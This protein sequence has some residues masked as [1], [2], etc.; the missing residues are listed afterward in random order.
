FKEAPKLL[1]SIFT[2]ITNLSKSAGSNKA[3]YEAKIKEIVTKFQDAGITKE[4]ILASAAKAATNKGYGIAGTT[5]G[6]V[7]GYVPIPEV[8][9]YDVGSALNVLY[10]GSD[11]TVGMGARGD[12]WRNEMEDGGD[13]FDNN[14]DPDPD[15]LV[16]NDPDA[17][18]KWANKWREIRGLDTDVDGNPL[19]IGTKHYRAAQQAMNNL[20]RQPNA[21]EVQNWL[22]ANYPEAYK[23]TLK[24]QG[25]DTTNYVYTPWDATTNPMPTQTQTETGED[26]VA[27]NNTTN[28]EGNSIVPDNKS[29]Q[30]AEDIIAGTAQGPQIPEPTKVEVGKDAT[31]MQMGEIDPITGQQ[32][33]APTLDP[34]VQAATTQAQQPDSIAASTIEAA[35]VAPQEKI[36]GAVGDIGDESIAKAAKVER[37]API[38]A[39]TVEIP[40]GALTQRVVGTLSPN[41]TAIAAQASGTTLSKVTRAK[42]QLR[43][44]GM[45]EEAITALGNDP[46]ELEDRLMDLTEAERG[47]IG[48]LPEEALVS[49]QI[50]SLLKGMESGEI[51]TWASP[52]VAAVEQMLAQRGLSASTVGRDN[53]FNAI[54]QSAVP[55]AQ[56]NAQAIQQSVAQT[57]DIESREELANVQMRQQTALQ[58]A[59]N[60]FQ[61]DM[62]QFS[63]DQQTALSNSKFLQTVSLTEASNRQQAIIQDA[64]ITSQMNLTDADFYQKTQIQ[65]SQAFLQMDLTNLN[66]KQ[67]ANILTAQLKQQNMLSN[68]AATNASRQ[69]NASSENQTQQFMAGLA[70]EVEKFNVQQNNSMSQFNAQSENANN[71]L[72]Y[73][74]EADVNKSNAAMANE[75]NKFNTQLAFNRE[76]WNKQNAQAVE[77]SNVA[78]RRQANT[79]NTAAANQ[80]SMQN[81]M[82]A[83]NLNGQA[84]SFL[85]QELRDQASF[86]FQKYE[87]SENRKAELYAQAIANEAQSAGDWE[88]NINSVGALI[89]SMFG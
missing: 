65:N 42:K 89:K 23:A 51:P 18:R 40:E 57:R 50:D 14:Y 64:T 69:F 1:T 71:A 7:K 39:A 87:N 80:V 4:E 79:I 45:S 6:K 36:V 76:Q 43:N 58:N 86:N 3:E 10:G 22:Y 8:G 82:N 63:A 56:S 73:N 32:I 41:A 28:E 59:G 68:Q 44:A 25:I 27:D 47:V 78:W 30:V 15:N 35:Q 29:R 55:I 62:A 48:N 16:P 70:S 84:L 67:Q 19:P 34:A 83:F 54:I 12:S 81:A 24:A 38:Q 61:M 88:S 11:G 85:W 60:V 75:I 46:E 26:T 49:N 21:E 33:T 37:V 5:T 77:Q 52:A 20:G 13:Y 2:D 17:S 66:N 53:L 72:R 31:T 9:A 74:V